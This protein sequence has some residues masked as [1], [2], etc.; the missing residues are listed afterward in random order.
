MLT[1]NKTGLLTAFLGSLP[2]HIAARLARAVELDRLMEGKT[3][4]HEEILRG[5]RP[6]LRRDQDGRMLT[7]L[8]LFCLPFQDLLSSEQRKTKQKGVIARGNVVPVWRWLSESLLP[9]E[10]LRYCTEVK[11]LIINKRNEEALLR[12]GEYWTL[13]SATLIAALAETKKARLALNGD[14][15]AADAA[16]IALLLAA[17][18]EM[19]KVQALMPAPAL[20][21]DELLWELRAVYDAVVERQPDAAPYVP[22]AAM[23]RL[24]RPWEG[25]RLPLSIARQHRDTLIS[26]TDMGLVGEILIERLNGLQTAILT[27]R[28]PMFDA[29]ALL[30][31]TRQFAELSVAIVKEIEVR[32]DGEWGQRLL[33]DRASV[34]EAMDKFMERAIKEMM[35]ALP[36]G[37]GTG[38]SA[39]FSRPSDAE[40]REMAMRYTRLVT[41]SRHFATG[42][43]FA[44]KQK[45]AAEELC[46]WLRRYNEDLVREMRAPDHPGVTE[47]QFPFCLELTA[48]LFSEEEA[49][50]LRRRGKAAL[51]TASA[52]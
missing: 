48:L 17:A 46:G 43:C 11:A 25:L 4:P 3:L 8:R 9:D 19:L 12:S 10:T 51:G 32:R 45:D 29:Y 26:K 1:A 40:K 15:P 18:P 14:L 36:M 28:H 5:L 34:G 41:G 42:G 38:A 6:V 2:G 21:T 47:V 37:R 31:Q 13:A 30:A 49:E 22:V 35:A 7:P 52:A 23:N 33:K 16:E 20:M 24:S 50:L 39:D 27:S 44:A